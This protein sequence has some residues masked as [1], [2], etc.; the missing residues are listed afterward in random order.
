MQQRIFFLILA[1]FLTITSATS[2]QE[3]EQVYIQGKR[4]LDIN[5]HS[6]DK[7]AKR[8]ERTQKQLLNKLK[9]KEQR[10]A[11]RLRRTDSVAYARLKNDPLTYDSIAKLA[12][13][14]DSATLAARTLKGGQKAVDSLKGVYNFLQGKAGKVTGALNSG[15]GAA[16]SAGVNSPELSGYSSEL[17][18]LQ[19]RLSYDQYITDLTSKR[20]LNLNS[21]A[22]S[23]STV[24]GMQKELYYAKAKIGEW[25]KIA[26]DPSLLE[27]KA[28]EYLQGTKGFDLSMN[29]STGS[30]SP[31]GGAGGGLSV[32]D[33]E[34]M[35]YQTKRQLNAALQQKFGGN[36]Q[37]IQASAG[38]ELDKWQNDAK[39]LESDLKSTKQ[40]LQSLKH[41][42]KPKFK[43]NPMRGLPFWQRIEK[44]YGFQTMRAAVNPDGTNKPAT[45]TLSAGAAYRQ[46]PKL[47]IGLALAADI[48][49]G[50]NWNSI[51]FSF[52]GLGARSFIT[53]QWQYGIGLYGGYERTWKESAFKN[54]PEQ[55]NPSAPVIEPSVHNKDNYSEAVVLGLTKRY[56][57]N[58][59]WNG[60]IQVL[61]DVWW[62]DKGLRSPIVLRFV[63]IN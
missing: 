49:L 54:K 9:R 44:Q 53:W 26:D 46:T 47:S 8:M 33:L 7:Y 27:E 21:I 42:Q 12:R 6:L 37:G 48:G 30:P 11:R 25:K 32:D 17:N 52:E 60:S 15:L 51:R 10:L 57:I 58:S 16:G 18:G 20:A 29:Q 61:Y 45:L 14:P 38:K 34:K 36:L 28:L 31:F 35:G 24:T 56:R 2:A 40:G 1:C 41:T 4:Y 23:N 50:Q 62:Q 22:G 19:G 55:T 43:I 39:G 59:K 13:H 63:N 3:N 5:I